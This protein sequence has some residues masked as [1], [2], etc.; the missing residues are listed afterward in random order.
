MRNKDELLICIMLSERSQTPFPDDSIT[1]SRKGECSGNRKQIINPK[2]HWGF[3]EELTINGH[4][5][6]FNGN[7]SVS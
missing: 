3:K 2:D 1:V 6:T 7:C 5:N 4:G